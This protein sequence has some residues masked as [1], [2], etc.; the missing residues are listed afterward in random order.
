LGD[1]LEQSIARYGKPISRGKGDSTNAGLPWYAFKYGSCEVEEMFDGG[2]VII[3]VYSKK[4]DGA[5]SEEEQ[6][7]ILKTES[8]GKAWSKSKSDPVSTIWMR[9][10]G[11]D[12]VYSSNHMTLGASSRRLNKDNSH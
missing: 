4:D 8:V 3:E 2:I 1:T 9:E 7:Q 12:A 6:Q 11:A 5:I 10:D